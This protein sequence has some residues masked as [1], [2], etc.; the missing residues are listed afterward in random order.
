MAPEEF[1]KLQLQRFTTLNLHPSNTDISV[2]VAGI[3]NFFNCTTACLICAKAEC[4]SLPGC[5][6]LPRVCCSLSFCVFGAC[7][8]RSHRQHEQLPRWCIPGRFSPGCGDGVPSAGSRQTLGQSSPTQQRPAGQ[9]F[10]PV[11]P[12]RC[13]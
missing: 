11:A 6:W 12:W 5:V 13:L 1:L 10:L 2:A 3:L 4:K 9:I 7:W 8:R